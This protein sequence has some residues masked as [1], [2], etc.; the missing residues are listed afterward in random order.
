METSKTCPIDR[1]RIGK[2]DLVGAPRVV[3]ELLGELRVRCIECKEE[4]KRDDF[5]RHEAECEARKKENSN[6][7]EEGQFRKSDSQVAGAEEDMVECPD[8]H[9]PMGSTKIE[10]S[11][12]HSP[13]FESELTEL[14]LLYADPLGIVS[15]YPSTVS[16]LLSL[17]PFE[18]PRIPP[19]QFLSSRSNSLS[20]CTLRMPS[21]RS[22]LNP[23]IR[24]SRH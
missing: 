11:S 2:K 14:A 20:S 23:H 22:S 6:Q 9:E 3:L 12:L 19:P 1:E 18:G 16:L 10:A 13:V 8:C 5:G 24:S 15:S 21:Y 17:T 7:D 4:M